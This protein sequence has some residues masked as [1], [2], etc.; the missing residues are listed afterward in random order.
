M[1]NICLNQTKSVEI[2]FTKPGRGRELAK[3]FPPREEITRKESVEI[4]GVTFSNRFS[5]REHVNV[6]LAACQ[7]TLFALRTLRAHGLDPTTLQTVFNAVAVGKLRYASPAWYG[8][9]SAEDRERIEVFLRKSKR[10]GYCASGAQSFAA[11]CDDADAA[12]FESIVSNTQHVLYQLL[13]PRVQRHYDLRPRS[14]DY[15]LPRLMLQTQI[16]L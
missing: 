4:L 12:L 7:Q 5:T 16:L 6:T 15:E 13:P 14:H 8:F 3:P 11:M 1:N 10:A 9:T 2:I